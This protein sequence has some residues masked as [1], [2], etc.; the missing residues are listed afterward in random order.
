MNS[1]HTDK[2]Y[3]QE[4]KSLKEKILKM[5]GRVEEMIAWSIE[6]LVNRDSELAEKVI[7]TDHQVNRFEVEIDEDCLS[8][9]ALRQPI[10]SDLR[11]ITTG[12]KIVTDLE[13]IGDMAVNVAE[14][15]LE[16]NEEPQLKPYI[17]IPR[18][19]QDIEKMIQDCLDAFVWSN[20]ELAEDVC[21]RD[22]AIDDLYLRIYR[23]NAVFITHRTINNILVARGGESKTIENAW[24][25]CLRTMKNKPPILQQQPCLSGIPCEF[26]KWTKRQLKR[27]NLTDIEIHIFNKTVSNKERVAIFPTRY[28]ENISLLMGIGPSIQLAWDDFLVCYGDNT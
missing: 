23:H 15:V 7:S 24:K 1:K 17:D 28:N 2:K 4:L 19:A 10:A 27:H 25:N 22:D 8:L 13:R 20:F 12:L 26:Q 5:G 21:K 18:M 9:L 3:S 14:R 11:F 6:A 16:L